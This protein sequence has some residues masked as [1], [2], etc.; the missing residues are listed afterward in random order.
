MAVI[1][2][3]TPDFEVPLDRFAFDGQLMLDLLAGCWVGDVLP[4]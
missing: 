3:R 2:P 1:Y 4:R